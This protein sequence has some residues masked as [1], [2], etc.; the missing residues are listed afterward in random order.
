MILNLVEIQ[1]KPDCLAPFV[2]ATLA[3]HR[4]TRR[5]PGN[6]RFDVV[7]DE[8]DP[9]RF[10]LYEVFRD[11]EAIEAH[12]ETEHYRIWKSAVEPWMASPRKGTRYRILA[13]E[14]PQAF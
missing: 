13:P 10:V 4:G 3:N 11:L 1:V 12:R 7:Q 2:E 6:L 14:R 9:T 8:S 5:E